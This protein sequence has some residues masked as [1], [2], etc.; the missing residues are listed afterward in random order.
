MKIKLIYK[1]SI[2]FF[3]FQI[4]KIQ[5]SLFP[6]NRVTL[7]CTKILDSKNGFKIQIYKLSKINVNLVFMQ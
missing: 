4:C 5:S 3:F 7:V 6:I 1:S 2:H